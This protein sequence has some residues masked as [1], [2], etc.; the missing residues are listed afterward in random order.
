M[1]GYDV[2]VVGGGPSGLSAAIT[3]AYYKITVLVI[4]SASAGGALVN[5]YPWKTVANYLG[6]FDRTGA[7]VAR[8]MV[9]HAVH[10]GVTIMQNETVT[11]VRRETN[12]DDSKE[13]I[14]VTTSRGKYAAKAVVIACGLGSPRKLGIEGENLQDVT[15]CLPDPK[16]YKGKKIFVVG[17]GDTAVE[18][19]VELKRSGADVSVVHRKD[20][21]R[22]T[23]KNVQCA[24]DECVNVMWNTE[25]KRIEGEGKVE[26][27]HLFNNKDVT[28]TVWDADAVLFSLGTVANTELLQRIGLKLSDKGNLVV[29]ADMKTNLPGIF[30]SGDVVGKWVR[31]PQA[32]GEGALAG[33]NAFKYV[34]NPYWG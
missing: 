21:F 15:F 29:S 22:A 27:L 10:E 17:G 32:V 16:K 33:L 20:E 30:A 13:H 11:D 1:K 24:S 8:M 9:D 26:R 31:I 25:V 3:A 5:Q 23:E 7:D 14:I 12:P 28:D 2:I 6:I 18:C 34:K 4:D 19:A